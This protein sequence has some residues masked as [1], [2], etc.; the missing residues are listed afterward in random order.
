MSD[1]ANKVGRARDNIDVRWDDERAKRIAQGAQALV[2]RQ[3]RTRIAAAA[4][5]LIIGAGAGAFALA[6]RQPVVVRDALVVQFSDGSTARRADAATVVTETSTAPELEVVQLSNG[7]ATF[8]VVRNPARVFRVQ[9][10]NVTVEVL[11]T[12][13]LVERR[14]ASAW[15]T[16]ESGRVRVTSVQGVVELHTGDRQEFPFA[17]AAAQATGGAAAL[18]PA[19]VES[20]PAV[21]A[22]LHKSP[23]RHGG[24]SAHGSPT[25]R[26]QVLAEDGDY[27]GAYNALHGASEPVRD[28]AAELFLAAD[29]A[30][31]S[32]HP[33]DAVAPLRTLITRHG[34]DARA[35]L[36]AFTLG[37]VLIE[38][39]SPREA[40][41]AF[42]EAQKLDPQGPMAE[43]ALAR[44]VEALSRS[45][46]VHSA[47]VRAEA[48]VERYPDGRRIRAV[49]RFGN[50]E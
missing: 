17:L 19:A 38:L 6:S 43:D 23:S 4:L 50:L 40:A 7:A 33:A 22:P 3:R 1:L 45:G 48:Y 44:E 5:V 31:L 12:H 11:G 37:N 2:R 24:T 35:P 21:K 41:A 25:S 26:W 29:V 47:R 27:D 14:D 20:V 28:D 49:R 42:V 10:A 46:D 15:V 13:F 16:V 36:A 30:R 34:D 32:H 9:V 8:D 18:E 39:G